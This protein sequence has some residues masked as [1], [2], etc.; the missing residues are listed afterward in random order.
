MRLREPGPY[1]VYRDDEQ[2]FPPS[3]ELTFLNQGNEVRT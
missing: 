1:L 2:R 3:S